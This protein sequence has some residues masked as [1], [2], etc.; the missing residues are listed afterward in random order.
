MIGSLQ[1]AGVPI[2]IRHHRT[3]QRSLVPA[4]RAILSILGNAAVLVSAARRVTLLKAPE[5]LTVNLA[6]TDIGM[7]LSMYPL[8]ISSAFN[9]AW[10]GGDTTCLYYSLMGMIFSI[11]SIM[12][13]AVMGMVRYLVT[14]S[15]PKTGIRFKR[16]TIIMVICGIWLYAI[17][18]AL[19]PLLGWGSYG[20]EPFGLACS[21]DWT[22][23]GESLNHA[24]FIMTLSILCT[25][26]PCLAIVFTYFGIAWKLHRAYQSIQS[27][28]FQYGNIEKKITLMA[29]MISTGFLIAWTP[30][31]SVSFWSM[32]HSQEQDHMTPFITLLPCLFAKSSTVYNPVIY[33]IFQRTTRQELQRLQRVMFCC[34]HQLNSAAEVEKAE[35]Q[36]GKGTNCNVYENGTD[37]TCVGLV[38][39]PCNQSG[40]QVMS[41]E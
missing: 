36:M 2:T 10:I 22:G 29:V 6:V 8:S 19:F 38:G 37:E 23:Y 26:L 28:D 32:F 1:R 27:N 12:T 9:H 30:Y 39:S 15:P 7:A 35:V 25:F 4:T 14:G 41:L 33:F 13:L 11:T 3:P 5:L 21:I 17:L 31:V 40:R 18:W 20:P 34:Y 16:R 24:T